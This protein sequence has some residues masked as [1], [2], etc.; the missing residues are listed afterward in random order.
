MIMKVQP[1]GEPLEA[2]EL[3]KA[4]EEIRKLKAIEGVK[5]VIRPNALRF[6]PD[7][8]VQLVEKR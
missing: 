8:R 2:S 4:L 5:V 6:L 7:G 3:E 1:S